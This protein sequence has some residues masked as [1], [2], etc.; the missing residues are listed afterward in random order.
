MT[1]LSARYPLIWCALCKKN[2]PLLLIEMEAD[3][4]N[5]HA[6][7]DL[8]CSNCRLVIATLHEKTDADDD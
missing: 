3:D 2:Q 6:A 5:D 1:Q 7:M 8:M 4:N